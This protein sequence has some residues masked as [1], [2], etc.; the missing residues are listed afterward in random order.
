[1]SETAIPAGQDLDSAHEAGVSR[2]LDDLLQRL[3]TLLETFAKSEVEHADA[4]GA[5]APEHRGGAVNLV[6]FT[7]LRQHDVRALQSELMDL[8]VTSLA[9]TEANVR[10]KV[11]AARNVIAAL[12]GDVDLADLDVF[13]RALVQGDE[14]LAANS[15]AVF[16]PMRSGRPTRIM[17]TLPSEAGDQPELVASFVDAGM[18]V[19]RVNCAHDDPDTWARMAANVKDAAASASRHVLVSMDL[20]GPKLRTGPIAD[21]PAV[22]RARVTRAESGQVLAPASVWLTASDRPTP[23][24]QPSE[25]AARPTLEVQV[26]R[27]WLAAR[28][29]GDRIKVTD[30]RRR[31]RTLTVTDVDAAGVLATGDQS[32]YLTNGS[33][34]SCR[35]DS[36][37]AGGVRPTTLRLSLSPGDRLILTVDLTAVDLPAPGATARIGCTLPA[38]IGAMRPGDAV[39]ID[40]GAIAAEVE[41]VDQQEATLRITRTKPGGQRLGAEKG[42]NLPDTVLPLPALTDDDES[43]LP[44]IAQHADMVAVSFVRT[45]GDVEHV[46]DRLTAAGAAHLGLLLKI[47]TRQ[48]FENLPAI[49]LVA[50]RHPRLG[51]MIARG[52]LAVEIGFERLAEVPRQILALSEAAHVP[53]IWATQVLES[54]AKT[55]Q[56]SRAEITDVAASQRADCVMLNKGPYIV[57]AIEVLDDILARMGQVQRK[58]RTLMRHIHSWDSQ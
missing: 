1:V 16:G 31:R 9:T 23:A 29:P 49:L 30:V 10:A 57:D 3:E 52:D 18:D 22:G 42:I 44:F 11:L 45:P 43:H 33:E 53:S 7:A 6:H 34:L 15:L 36:T 39:L 2:S 14:T 26:D 5:V 48:G 12:R 54:L 55:G 35:G 20:P 27:A 21:G 56:P 46:L 51:V 38:A 37:V 17:V 58:G 41:S 32:V 24:P 40:D 28:R 25:S 13:R 4:I 47:E 50:M 8:G 19:A